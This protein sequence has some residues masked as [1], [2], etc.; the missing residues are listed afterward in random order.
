MTGNIRPIYPSKIEGYQGA[1]ISPNRDNLREN[2]STFVEDNHDKGDGEVVFLNTVKPEI[3]KWLWYGRIPYGKLTVLD[4]DPGLGKST[5]L[6]DIAARLT[7]GTPMPGE[8]VSSEKASV[9]LLSAEDGLGDTIA[10]RLIAACA[11]LTR[12]IARMTVRDDKGERLPEIDTDIATLNHDIEL[13]GAKLVIIDP[14]MAYLSSNKSANKDQDVR[15]VLAPLSAVAERTGAAIIVIR[16]LNIAQGNDAIY[17]GGGSIGI[18]GAARSGLLVAKDQ[19][20]PTERRRILASSKC[21]LAPAPKSIAYH[22][23]SAENGVAR[24][25]WEGETHHTATSLLAGPIDL[26]EKPALNEACKFLIDTLRNGPSPV[27]GITKEARSAGISTITLRR[28]K[29]ILQ[30]TASKTGFSPSFWV[31]DLPIDF[32]DNVGRRLSSNNEDVHENERI[33]DMNNFEDELTEDLP[34]DE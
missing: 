31:W 5:M 3:V 17:R 33:G 19:E 14:L 25:E 12:V 29:D 10:P 26:D 15:R 32:D 1:P 7:T 11:D 34:F 27:S 23:E 24:I 9:L 21:N 16:H 13:Y 8:K 2:M 4:G 6:L 30:I 18:I 20:D 28:A 22:F